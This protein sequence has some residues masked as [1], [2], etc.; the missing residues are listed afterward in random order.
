MIL[1][2]ISNN[3]G[4]MESKYKILIAVVVIALAAVAFYFLTADNAE[5]K[6]A[7][8][9][10]GTVIDVPNTFD[11]NWTLNNYGAKIFTASSKR[12]AVISY[13]LA[14]NYVPSGADRFAEARDGFMNGSELVENYNGNDIVQKTI[15]D[16]SYYIVSMS[17]ET[18]HDNIIIACAS[19]DTLKHMIDSLH[20]GDSGFKYIETNSTASRK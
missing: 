2:K 16:T 20:F 11:G 18:T 19:M 1:N 6:T 4:K 7:N 13:N 14:Q 17:N 8:L 3:G 12:T 15:N 10:N 5:F 9:T